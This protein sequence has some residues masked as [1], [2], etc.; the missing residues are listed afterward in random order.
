MSRAEGAE[1]IL[2][3]AVTLGGT[4]GT[5]AL[6]LQGVAAAA[7]V[8]KALVAYH[9]SG[10]DGLW[11]ALTERLVENEEQALQGIARATDP[12]TAWRAHALAARAGRR[13]PLL[14]ALLLEDALASYGE[15]CWPRLE[16][17]AAD[18]GV[19][20]LAALDLSPRVVK[21]LLGRVVLRHL[22]G[23]AA[24]PAGAAA[25]V[26]DAELDAFAL[27]LLALGR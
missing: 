8:S 27:A 12:M 7:G 15:E 18:A 13:L 9:F 22:T 19:A 10:H 14:A 21:P 5:R 17:A 25:D 26:Q 4:R 20:V 2:A 24:G 11:R 3:A 23:F 16:Q 1:A 6:T